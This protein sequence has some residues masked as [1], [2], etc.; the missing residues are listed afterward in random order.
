MEDVL[1]KARM[2]L[3]TTPARWLELVDQLPTDLLERPAA[4]GEWS[5]RDCL[6]HLLDTE[7]LVFPVRVRAFLAGQ[8]L[9]TFDP[10]AQAQERNKGVPRRLAEE[11]A[12]LRT[13]SL[14][15][16]E[17]LNPSDL[18]LTAMHSEYGQVTLGEMVHEW[19][20]HD[21]MHTV[22]AERAI[23]QPFIAGCGPWKPFFADHTVVQ[24]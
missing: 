19:A 1:S 15:L 8:N 20:A 22:Q 17:S 24:D 11:F 3:S 7:E 9:V 21:L 16:L 13:E 10:D 18:A 12:R 4:P 2:V 23:M 6:S 14:A 5:A